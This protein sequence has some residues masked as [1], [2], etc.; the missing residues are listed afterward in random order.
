MN[1]AI[2]QSLLHTLNQIKEHLEATRRDS[3]LWTAEDVGEYLGKK[4]ARYVMESLVHVS[5]FPLPRKHTTLRGGVERE[6]HPLWD[7]NEI[8]A[9]WKRQ[10]KVSLA[11]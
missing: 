7:P 3:R 4:S 1:T 9:W 5:G 8:K 10:P 2:E 11:S 6:S